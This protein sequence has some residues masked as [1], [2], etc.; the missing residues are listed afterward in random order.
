MVLVVG[1][2]ARW[3]A[4]WHLQ[5]SRYGRDRTFG[6]ELTAA[7]YDRAAIGFGAE[8]VSVTELSELREALAAAFSSRGPVCLNVQILSVRSP[9]INS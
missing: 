4:E 1:N 7:R 5:V 9:A 6:T 8:A 2:D 3:A